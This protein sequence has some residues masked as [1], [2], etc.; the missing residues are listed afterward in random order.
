MFDQLKTFF[1]DI[2][3]A[4]PKKAFRDD[5]YRLA[6]VALLINIAKIDGDADAAERDRLTRL[7]EERFGLDATATA[8]LMA[9]GEES[10]REAIDFFKFTSLLKRSLDEERRADIVEMMWDIALADGAIDEFE[11][12][13]IGRLAELLDVSNNDRVLSRQR[14]LKDSGAKGQG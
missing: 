8:Q 4:E 3:G 12:S 13:T 9:D 1:A 2:S 11:E 6:A 10:D 7:I 5:D 14:A